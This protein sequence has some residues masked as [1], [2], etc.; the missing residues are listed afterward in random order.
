MPSTV[1]SAARAAPAGFA[2]ASQPWNS[3]SPVL[4]DLHNVGVVALD[5]DGD[6]VLSAAHGGFDVKPLRR[7]LERNRNVVLPE[8]LRLLHVL[9]GDVVQHLEHGVGVPAKRAER[10]RQVDPGSACARNPHPH[11]VLHHITAHAYLDALHRAGKEAGGLRHRISNGDRLRAAC[12]GGELLAKHGYVIGPRH[13]GG[14]RLR[15]AFRPHNVFNNISKQVSMGK[16]R[17]DFASSCCS[18]SVYTC[19]IIQFSNHVN[20]QIKFLSEI[21]LKSGKKQ[22]VFAKKNERAEIL[23]QM[24]RA[25]RTFFTQKAGRFGGEHS[26]FLKRCSDKKKRAF[27]RSIWKEGEHGSGRDA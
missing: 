5:D 3:V 20:R 25:L 8:F 26:F 19:S 11:G 16:R 4:R 7:V 17:E 10:C 2:A 23:P 12:G 6:G 21:F 1:R 14:F 27:A 24:M 13:A 9:R 18:F 22:G 15:H